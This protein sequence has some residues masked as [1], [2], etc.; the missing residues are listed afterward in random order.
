[1]QRLPL[2]G[3]S[4]VPR[5][6]GTNLRGIST[7]STTRQF[8]NEENRRQSTAVILCYNVLII[9]MSLYALR[10]PPHTAG[11]NMQTITYTRTHRI[12]LQ[13]VQ[14]LGGLKGGRVGL[15]D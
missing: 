13:C 5:G 2:S 7:L 1:M 11:C 14:H 8:S 12:I 6:F 4:K 3:L 15:G 9:F 10:A